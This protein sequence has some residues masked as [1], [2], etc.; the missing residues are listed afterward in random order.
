[1]AKA[2]GHDAEREQ[3]EA[4][5]RTPSPDPKKENQ[6]ASTD[7]VPDDTGNA[8][9]ENVPPE[10]SAADAASAAGQQAELKRQQD[11]IDAVEKAG[12]DE[13]PRLGGTPDDPGLGR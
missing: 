10:N 11:V 5:D 6:P 7:S 4:P 3:A 1:M 8:A 12:R 9:A 2:P 13:L